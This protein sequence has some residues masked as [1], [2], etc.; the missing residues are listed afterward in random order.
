MNDI[1]FRPPAHDHP[2]ALPLDELTRIFCQDIGAS[3]S[4]I[5]RDLRFKFVNQGF[6]KALG[7]TPE[8][9]VGVTLRE[10]YGEAHHEAYMPY[11]ER[12]LAGE[13]LSYERFG[14]MV[15]RD[16]LWRTVSLRPWRDAQDQ[17]IGVISVSMVVHELKV[18]S[19]KLRAANERLSSH[20]EN[21]PLTV[22]E[23]DADLN[24][25]HCSYRAAQMF[26]LDPRDLTNRPL[27]DAL[28]GPSRDVLQAAF[29]RLQ[30][31]QE[32]RNRAESTHGRPDGAVVHCEWFNSALT[33]SQGRVT[34]VMSLVEDITARVDAEMQLRHMALHDQLTGLPNR[35]ALAERLVQALARSQRAGPGPAQQVALLFIDLD[36]FKRVN[37]E[38]GHAAGDEVL[39]EVAHRLIG[40][41][42]DTDTV[43]RL[44]GDEFVVLMDTEVQDDSPD[45]VAQRVLDALK[46]PVQFKGGAAPIGASIGVAEHPPLPGVATDLLK[47][48]DAAMYEAKHAGKGTVRRAA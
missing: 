46:Q 35:S 48:A 41:V 30:T 24:I 12:A 17:V 40:C 44:G 13:T 8:T 37:D 7:F 20:M 34:S 19:E 29:A 36:G 23:L 33:D 47:R 14:R 32:E 28:G 16:G 38:Y 5:G 25:T 11:V 3:I 22:L 21:S 42:R 6:A 15:L 26:G 27:L 1:V 2:V 39:R 43:A 45:L 10:I 31:G 18:S 4:I 9:M